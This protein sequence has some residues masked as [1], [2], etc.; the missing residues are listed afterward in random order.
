MFRRTDV[1]DD[2]AARM[3]SDPK[4]ADVCSDSGILNPF[5]IEHIES[6]GTTLKHHVGAIENGHHSVASKLVD[7]AAMPMNNVD[8]FCEQRTH[9]LKEFVRFHLFGKSGEITHICETDGELAL[10]GRR[11]ISR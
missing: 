10:L 2:G 4:T 6:T 7:V 8:L 3:N 5:A 11:Q 1:P 9:Q